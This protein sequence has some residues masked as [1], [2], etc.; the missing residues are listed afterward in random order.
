[1]GVTVRRA[2]VWVSAMALALVGCSAGVHRDVAGA[3]NNLWELFDHARAGDSSGESA[4]A[5]VHAP[6]AP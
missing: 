3:A 4:A 2:A 1:M 6:V 5:A